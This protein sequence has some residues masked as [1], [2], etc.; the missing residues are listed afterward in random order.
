MITVIFAYVTPRVST[1]QDLGIRR[2]RLAPPVNNVT[3]CSRLRAQ[4]GGTHLLGQSA[5]LLRRVE[6]FVVE[7]GEV[8]GQAEP[9][10]VRRRHFLLADVEGL[11][12]GLLRVVHRVFKTHNCHQNN[13]FS[14]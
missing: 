6:D 8:E 2:A 1:T 4:R 9:D 12:V 7:D 11:L 5:G 3:C 14:I 10:G 13:P